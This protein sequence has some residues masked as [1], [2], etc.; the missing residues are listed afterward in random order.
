MWNIYLKAVA[1]YLQ[2]NYYGYSTAE[3]ERIINQFENNR[4]N[5]LY[6]ISPDCY[7]DYRGKHDEVI[8]QV[9]KAQKTKRL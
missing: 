4:V 7:F 2:Q 6:L 5:I 1:N 3:S 9:Q 8:Y